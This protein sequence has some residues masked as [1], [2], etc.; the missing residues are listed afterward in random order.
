MSMVYQIGRLS[1]IQVLCYPRR[2]ELLVSQQ[3]LAC[4]RAQIERFQ[5]LMVL[6]TSGTDGIQL[7]FLAEAERPSC[8]R[9][10]PGFVFKERLGREHRTDRFVSKFR[11]EREVVLTAQ[12]NAATATLGYETI[13]RRQRG[14]FD[15]KDVAAE[16]F[17]LRHR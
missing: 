17:A 11:H 8:R 15:V 13:A 14:L 10:L 1:P 5:C 16:I 2:D 12:Q 6:E 3:I 7:L 9:K 4:D